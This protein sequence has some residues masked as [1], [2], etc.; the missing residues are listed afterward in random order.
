M[1]D[2]KKSQSEKKKRKNLEF[3]MEQIF[4]SASKAH[5]QYCRNPI[6]DCSIE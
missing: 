6:A 3:D 1:R 2:A 5:P 4:I